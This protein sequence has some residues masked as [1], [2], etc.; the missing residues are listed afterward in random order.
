MAQ[1]KSGFLMATFPGQ[2]PRQVEVP[3]I[4]L[5]PVAAMKRPASPR[6]VAKERPDATTVP[7]D[8]NDEVNERADELE[9]PEPVATGSGMQGEPTKVFSSTLI[10]TDTQMA[11]LL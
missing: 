2:A 4:V 10:H 3:N 6:P 7:E 5:L 11:L 9:T 1:G 8:L